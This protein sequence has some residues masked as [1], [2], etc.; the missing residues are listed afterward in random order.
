MSQPD[1]EGA[2]NLTRESVA[3][4]ISSDRVIFAERV[5]TREEHLA[6]LSLAGL[7]LDPFPYNAHSSGIDALW[8]GVPMVALLGD[9][10]PGRVGASL[11]HA[12]NLPECVASNVEDYENLCVDLATNPQRLERMRLALEGG[13]ADLPLFDMKRFVEGLESSYIKMTESLHQGVD[14]LSLIHILCA[15]EPESL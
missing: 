9:T 11:L 15:G 5:A 14:E 7:A 1:A 10:F 13:R 8:S 4:G 2:K 12:V 3:R 6:R